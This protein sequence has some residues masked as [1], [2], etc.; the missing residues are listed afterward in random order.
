MMPK[1]YDFIMAAELSVNP[2]TPQI[3]VVNNQWSL[4]FNNNPNRRH[5]L[6]TKAILLD[7]I[8]AKVV[9]YQNLVAGTYIT[10]DFYALHSF[11]KKFKFPILTHFAYILH[12][13]A[14]LQ[15]KNERDF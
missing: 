11:Q 4:Y 14:P 10:D 7:G 3:L 12:S 2:S 9:T 13:A 6:F 8:Y 1:F 5:S 15:D